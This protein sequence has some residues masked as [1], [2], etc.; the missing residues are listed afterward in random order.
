MS[1]NESRRDRNA[2]ASE[3]AYACSPSRSTPQ[4]TST[5]PVTAAADR[6]HYLHTLV[7]VL[8]CTIYRG[9]DTDRQPH[10]EVLTEHTRRR[11][12]PTRQHLR[13]LVGDHMSDETLDR[14]ATDLTAFAGELQREIEITVGA[15]TI[16]RMCDLEDDATDAALHAETIQSRRDFDVDA[17][18]RRHPAGGAR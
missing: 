18:I 1:R 12:H 15:R 6:A 4:L 8:D 2:A 7:S 17:S 13:P 11:I 5:G 3:N 9:P 14:L 16:D 10:F